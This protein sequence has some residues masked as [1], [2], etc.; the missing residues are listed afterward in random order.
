M[1]R[2][3]AHAEERKGEHGEVDDGEQTPLIGA[4]G[5]VEPWLSLKPVTALMTA[6]K[7]GG[8]AHGVPCAA[9]GR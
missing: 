5:N 4:A 2:G 7:F 1:M 8:A 3:L 6:E 9:T